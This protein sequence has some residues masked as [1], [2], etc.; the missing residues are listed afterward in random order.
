MENQS[1]GILVRFLK[2]R[3][4]L[5]TTF[6]LVF[7]PVYIVLLLGSEPIGYWWGGFYVKHELPSMFPLE[8]PFYVMWAI[9]SVVALGAG[10]SAWR[11]GGLSGGAALV[12]IILVGAP[13]SIGVFKTLFLFN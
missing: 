3:I 13:Y 5:S 7:V 1:E 12:V 6:W 4:P 9:G 2:G 11:T 10:V 8:F